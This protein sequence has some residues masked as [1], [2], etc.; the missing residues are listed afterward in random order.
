LEKTINYWTKILNVTPNP[1]FYQFCILDINTN[2]KLAKEFFK[3]KPTL[4]Q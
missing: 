1:W 4:F 2:P 3:D